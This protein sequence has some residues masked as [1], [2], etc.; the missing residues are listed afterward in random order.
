MP[1]EGNHDEVRG[2]APEGKIINNHMLQS[3][4]FSKDKDLRILAFEEAWRQRWNTPSHKIAYFQT[5]EEESPF[6]QYSSRGWKIHIAF[7]KGKEKDMAKFLYTNGL[8]F[9]VEGQMGTYFNGTKASG[10]TLYIGS[11]EN[12]IAIADYLKQHAGDMLVNGNVAMFD[13]KTINIGSGSDIE[14]RPKIAARFDVARTKYGWA[15]GN[16][17]YAEHGIASWLEDL[18]GIPIL[19]SREIEVRHIEDGWNHYTTEQKRNYFYPRLNKFYE[20]AKA[21]LI[22][23]FG[24]EFVFGSKSPQQTLGK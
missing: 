20:E 17:K 24:E 10:S 4:I 7:E 12:M 9:K 14:V 8:Y 11:H 18:T 1:D 2:V 15:E 3:T 16:E 22:K 23:D 5:K 19:K 6:S 21:E 13:D